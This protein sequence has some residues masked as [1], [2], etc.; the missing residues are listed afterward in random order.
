MDIKAMSQTLQ[1]SLNQKGCEYPGGLNWH[2]SKIT[3]FPTE[4]GI[5]NY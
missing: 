2:H 1:T 5:E 4:S 3:K